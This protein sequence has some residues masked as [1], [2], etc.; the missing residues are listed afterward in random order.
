[1]ESVN[2]L[3]LDPYQ[4]L[5][6]FKP[7]VKERVL[8]GGIEGRGIGAYPF[9]I[10]V[11]LGEKEFSLRCY[12]VESRIDPLLGRLDFWNLFSINF[13]NRKQQTKFVSLN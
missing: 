10:R 8:I 11:R 7:K 13:D 1:M 5:F 9:K 6:G 12:F 2:T 4:E 3:S